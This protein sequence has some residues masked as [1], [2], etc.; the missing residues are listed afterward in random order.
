MVFKIGRY[1][2]IIM[3]ED[4]YEYV[5]CGKGGK[6]IKSSTRPPVWKVDYDMLRTSL[7]AM[8]AL[9]RKG[10]SWAYKLAGRLFTWCPE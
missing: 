3:S 6:K 9:L 5:L 1:P 2:V 8:L 4:E 10:Q 7:Q